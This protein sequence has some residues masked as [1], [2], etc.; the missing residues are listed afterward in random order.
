MTVGKDLKKLESLNTVGIVEGAPVAEKSVIFTQN[1]IKM[2]VTLKDDNNKYAK[3][4][5]ENRKRPQPH[6]TI[7]L[8]ATKKCW[9]DKSLPRDKH[10]HCLP[11]FQWSSLNACVQVPL[12]RV[13]RLY[14]G[15]Y[16]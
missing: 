14:F 1:Q 16:Y 9:Q 8:Q 12:Y 4:D 5:R 11:I 15:T 2:I 7:Y 6:T 10:A 13:N 3:L